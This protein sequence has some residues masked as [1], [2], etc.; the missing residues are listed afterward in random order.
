MH[1]LE[2][3]PSNL[4][5][6]RLDI[7]LIVSVSRSPIEKNSIGSFF[8]LRILGSCCLGCSEIIAC[9][10][11]PLA[12]LRP[13]KLSAHELVYVKLRSNLVLCTNSSYDEPRDISAD[14]NYRCT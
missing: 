3:P 8:G 14:A 5:A 12:V 11:S 13:T 7:W 9:M 2:V 1:A 10:I 6:L 4:S